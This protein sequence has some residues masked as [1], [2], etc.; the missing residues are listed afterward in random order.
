MI[1]ILLL[2]YL[3]SGFINVVCVLYVKKKL[4]SNTQTKGLKRCVSAETPRFRWMDV[5]VAGRGHT[6]GEIVLNIEVKRRSCILCR[7]E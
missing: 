2:L 5:V 3:I 4:K 1:I 6:V 7:Y